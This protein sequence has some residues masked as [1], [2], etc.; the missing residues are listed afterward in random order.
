MAS[1][2]WPCVAFSAEQG[3][4]HGESAV[5]PRKGQVCQAGSVRVSCGMSS[6][7]CAVSQ[8]RSGAGR[9]ALFGG[10][11]EK[12]TFKC[13]PFKLLCEGALPYLLSLGLGSPSRVVFFL[14]QSDSKAY[15]V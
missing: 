2:A 7:E 11:V 10:I 14:S 12:Q 8:G 5:R 15:R 4:A 9:Q 1:P 13:C 3:A 6:L